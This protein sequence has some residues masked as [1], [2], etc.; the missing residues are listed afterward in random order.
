MYII[1][2]MRHTRIVENDYDFM[3]FAVLKNK[4]VSVFFF[5]SLN[6]EQHT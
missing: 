6:G 3:C 5:E 1:D 4:C 2:V